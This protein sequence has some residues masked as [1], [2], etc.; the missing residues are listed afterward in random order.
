M[1]SS[2]TTL[3]GSLAK[4]FESSVDKYYGVVK[5]GVKRIQ[6]NDLETKLSRFLF[7]YRITPHS[8]TGITRSE[9][10][11]RQL[12][13][14]LHLIK[15][16]VGRK[17][18]TMQSRQKMTHD[19]HAKVRIFKNGDLVYGLLYHDNKA[20][21]VPGTVEQQTGPVSYT[22]RLEGGAIV[23]RH[24]DQLQGRLA[25]HQLVPSVM[26]PLRVISSELVGTPQAEPEEAA[27]PLESTEA[28]DIDPAAVVAEPRRSARN[29][30]P[31]VLLDL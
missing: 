10:L 14:R 23:R 7:D 4:N 25:S 16:D 19:R 12:K 22:V 5:E 2:V 18:I 11:K 21:W 20:S 9:L 31:P 27:Q 24:I 15:P 26:H 6:G 8:T 13:T 29:R 30:K 28:R 1:L 3:R 17:V